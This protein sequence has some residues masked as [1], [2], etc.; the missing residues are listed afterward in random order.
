MLITNRPPAA[1]AKHPRPRR[2]APQ[3]QRRRPR[4]H[5][6]RLQRVPYRRARRHPAD[7]AT[8]PAP[9]PT[10]R[11]ER[12][13]PQRANRTAA[14]NRAP[15][16]PAPQAAQR[17]VDTPPP[18][19]VPRRLPRPPFADQPGTRP[20]TAR[21]WR[22][23]RSRDNDPAAGVVAAHPPASATSANA[24]NPSHPTRPRDSTGHNK[25][26]AARSASTTARSSATIN[27]TSSNGVT[28]PPRLT[29]SRF[30]RGGLNQQDH[31]H[32]VAPAAPHGHASPPSVSLNRRAVTI[33][34]VAQHLLKSA[35]ACHVSRR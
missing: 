29:P 20:A 3:H 25:R 10:R 14:A 8:R 4:A 16:L 15:S 11:I 5:A 13:S 22:R 17:P 30:R 24:N 2:P 27:T 9:A 18:T 21:K 28:R 1:R 33:Q 34:R 26:P 19:T 6:N 32:P 12:R 7:P 23:T 31:H 35:S